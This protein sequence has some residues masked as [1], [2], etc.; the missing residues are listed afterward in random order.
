MLALANVCELAEIN[1]DV[2]MD[3]LGGGGGKQARQ[4]PIKIQC[5]A[6][7]TLFTVTLGL[8]AGCLQSANVIIL[9]K[10]CF[11]ACF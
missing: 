6:A 10:K 1:K 9:S 5:R 8:Q 4:E 3:L 11:D 2:S 7:K